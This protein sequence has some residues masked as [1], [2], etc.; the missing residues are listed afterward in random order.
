[1][2]KPNLYA[3]TLSL[4]LAFGTTL[5]FVA[6]AMWLSRYAL[7]DVYIGAI[8]SFIILSVLFLSILPSKIKHATRRRPIKPILRNEEAA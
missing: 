5:V 6:V 8:W 2:T 3:V 7:T 1:M 4:A